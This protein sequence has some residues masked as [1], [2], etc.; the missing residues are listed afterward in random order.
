FVGAAF[1]GAAAF[2][3]SG[4]FSSLTFS[5]SLSGAKGEGTLLSSTAIYIELL[6]VRATAWISSPRLSPELVLAVKYKYFPSL[7]N[8][9]FHASLIPSVTWVDFT[10]ASEYRWIALKRLGSPFE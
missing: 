5:S 9:G 8:T 10:S 1:A 7:S 3:P 2:S 6:D 4:F